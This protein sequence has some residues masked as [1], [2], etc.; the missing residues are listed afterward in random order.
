MEILTGRDCDRFLE[1]SAI[2]TTCNSSAKAHCVHLMFIIL[3]VIGDSKL[4]K[5]IITY[6]QKN[7]ALRA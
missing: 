2:I 1:I 7:Y 3:N 6:L 4:C 5:Y